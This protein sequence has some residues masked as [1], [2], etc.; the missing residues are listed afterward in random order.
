MIR[1]LLLLVVVLFLQQNFYAQDK[2]TCD[3]PT[4]E[5]AL[6]LNS[7]TKCT[8][9][10]TDEEG[11]KSK[12]VSI[13]VTSRKRVIRK[14]DAVTG[15]GSVNTSHKLADL[16]KKASLVGSLD[17]SKEEV[18]EK[19]PFNLVEE[20]PLFSS[21][22]KVAI[23]EQEKCFKEEISNHI[24]KNF[25]YPQE[26]YDKSIQGRVLVQFVIE[27]DGSVGDLNIRGPYGGEILEEEAKRIVNKLPKFRPGKHNGKTVKVK[28]GI[29]IGFRIPGKKPSNVKPS[30]K[31][32]TITDAINM[33]KTDSAPLFRA[34]KRTGDNSVDCFNE[35]MIKHVNKY[36]AYPQEA[37]DKNIEGKVYAYF[38]V[39][40]NGDVVNIKT[41]GPKGGEVLE[42][43]VKKLVE[44]LPKL[45]P[46][47][48]SGKSVNVKYAFPI[49][50]QL[51]D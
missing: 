36:F 15:V 43:A 40:K 14:R 3:T 16:K 28:Y 41:R 37:V 23:Y 10:N 6:D 47:K 44:K 50:F 17:L 49:N 31:T 39:D 35:E 33:A 51:N 42:T 5:P 38:I 26:A 21:C 27:K 18:V 2:Q 11:N 22:E 19:V 24:K 8:I 46:G 20:I 32:I 34:C 13:Q 7:I 4:D 29:P 30:S 12:Q 1:K 25:R 9:E 45:E 48:K